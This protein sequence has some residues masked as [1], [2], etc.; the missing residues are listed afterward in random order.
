MNPLVEMYVWD[1]TL[2]A[3]FQA[4]HGK[5]ISGV[6]IIVSGNHCLYKLAVSNQGR[7]YEG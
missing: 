4:N 6:A 1:P 2:V 3:R 5:Y 7:F